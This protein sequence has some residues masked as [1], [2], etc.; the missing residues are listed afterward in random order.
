MTPAERIPKSARRRG[1]ADR[2]PKRERRRPPVRGAAPAEPVPV[3][4]L[5]LIEERVRAAAYDL[6]DCVDGRRG[7]DGPRLRRLE[8]EAAEVIAG[9]CGRLRIVLLYLGCGFPPP[10][11]RSFTERNSAAPQVPAVGKTAPA[12]PVRP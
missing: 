6:R 4:E 9:E 5:S 10:A 8:R 12:Q 7:A 3:E 11:E 1:P 2:I